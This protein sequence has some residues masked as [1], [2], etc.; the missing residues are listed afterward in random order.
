MFNLAYKN[1]VR[2]LLQ[3]KDV[4]VKDKDL[5]ELQDRLVKLK[6]IQDLKGFI[7]IA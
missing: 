6:G 3:Y 4:K 2:E 7:P 1:Q 5:Q